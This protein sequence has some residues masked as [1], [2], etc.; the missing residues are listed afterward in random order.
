MTITIPN[1]LIE[2]NEPS[3]I[4]LDEGLYLKQMRYMLESNIDILHT[5]FGYTK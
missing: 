5:V 1:Y 3:L 2:H 4:K